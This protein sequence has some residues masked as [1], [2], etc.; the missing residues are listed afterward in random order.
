MCAS[1]KT[2]ADREP[3]MRPGGLPLNA[4]ELLFWTS[5]STRSPAGEGHEASLICSET[6]DQRELVMQK[7]NRTL[8]SVALPV[9]AAKHRQQGVPRTKLRLRRL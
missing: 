3:Y 2:S 6:L 9:Y 4:V 1:V 7:D 5:T 8:Q